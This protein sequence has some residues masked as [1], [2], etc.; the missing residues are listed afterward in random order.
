[1]DARG[2]KTGFAKT[3]NQPNQSNNEP[4]LDPSQPAGFG[5]PPVKD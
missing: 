5:R 4:A 1:M 2:L 3:C